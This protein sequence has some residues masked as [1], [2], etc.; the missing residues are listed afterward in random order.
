MEESGHAGDRGGCGGGRKKREGRVW[1][2]WRGKRLGEEGARRGSGRWRRRLDGRECRKKRRRTMSDGELGDGG[3]RIRLR[4][5]CGGKE[6]RALTRR[7]WCDSA[8]GRAREAR[9]GLMEKSERLAWSER[10]WR[11]KWRR[12]ALNWRRPDSLSLSGW[13]T[14]GTA[15]EASTASAAAD[16]V[17]FRCL[18]IC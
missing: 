16:L 4:C 15:R 18:A 6:S 7:N 11:L 1:R 12:R 9:R 3:E 2:E 8:V 5:W 10:L 17:W 13:R 14:E